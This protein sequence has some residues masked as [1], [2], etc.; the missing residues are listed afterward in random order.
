MLWR[1]FF[2]TFFL[3]C[4][5]KFLRITEVKMWCM[6]SV[7]W[8]Q[9]WSLVAETLLILC[10]S[11]VSL[12]RHQLTLLLS[13]CRMQ[14]LASPEC[15]QCALM[16]L[17]GQQE[18]RP[19]CKNW[20]SGGVLAWLSVWSE[21]QTCIWP[22]WCHCHSLSLATVKSRLV[23]PFWYWLTQVVPDK[24]PLNGCVCAAKCICADTN[25]WMVLLLI[26]LSEWSC[27]LQ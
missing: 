22:S 17:V 1:L 11:A 6:I 12:I 26:L 21:V 19:A 13:C 20:L 4:L 24:G 7:H 2:F 9:C 25:Q 3:H 27:C 5:V 23:L 8:A 10:V 16:L 14:G 18:G 15:L